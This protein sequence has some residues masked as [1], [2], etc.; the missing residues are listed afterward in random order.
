MK[1]KIA[2]FTVKMMVEAMAVCFF[3]SHRNILNKSECLSSL[4]LTVIFVFMYR[5]IWSFVCSFGW[6]FFCYLSFVVFFV[7]LHLLIS[8]NSIRLCFWRR[9]RF[10]DK[11]PRSYRNDLIW[12][13][14]FAFRYLFYSIAHFFFF[15]PILFLFHDHFH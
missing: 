2:E 14:F 15:F 8:I 10:I 13:F 9:F 5:G 3:F 6:F 7:S 4:V 11:L 12:F 1:N